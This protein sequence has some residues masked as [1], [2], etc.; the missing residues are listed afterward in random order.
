MRTAAVAS[1]A[2][3][4]CCLVVGDGLGGGEV[5]ELLL[6]SDPERS[7]VLSLDSTDTTNCHAACGSHRRR[8]CLGGGAAASLPQRSMSAVLASSVM[9][10]SPQPRCFGT[11][12]GVS[13]VDATATVRDSAG[14][15]VANGT[16]QGT[17]CRRTC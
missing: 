2:H 1:H 8:S 9:A 5:A 13:H 7:S 11:S 10:S 17:I 12:E 14:A 16:S 3:Q 4:S 6:R 15:M